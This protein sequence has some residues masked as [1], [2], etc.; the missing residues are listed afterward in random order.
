M[1]YKGIFIIKL[2]IQYTILKFSSF[3]LDLFALNS[4]RSY[5]MERILKPEIIF[6]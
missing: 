3:F 4:Q 6:I 2:N 1:I 5:L